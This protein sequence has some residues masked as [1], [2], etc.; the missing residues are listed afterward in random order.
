MSYTRPVS[1]GLRAYAWLLTIL[2]LSF[3]CGGEKD[4]QPVDCSASTLS[5]SIAGSTDATS[6]QASD[7]TATAAAQG[8]G[9][10]VSYSINGVDFQESPEFTGLKAGNYV[11]TVT[12][13]S[14]C[15]STASFTIGVEGSILKIETVT[16]KHAGCEG[17]EGEISI[18]AAGDGALTYQLGTSDFQ[19]SNT[20]TGLASGVYSIRVRD[21]LGCE[22]FSQANVLAGTS[23]SGQVKNIIQVNCA[24]DGCHNGDEGQDLDW[25]IFSNVQANAEDI[26]SLS[27]NGD[28][29][30]SDSDLSLTAEEKALIACWVNDGALN[31]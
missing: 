11:L 22:V 16:T 8:A 24:V 21:E 9:D 25:T 20:F 2:S 7:G 19:T 3:G 14:T 6:C 27:L 28:M 15:T 5:V 13:L 18:S 4:P 23:Y 29:P 10:N 17:K 30:P 26:K 31:N 1:P 12:D